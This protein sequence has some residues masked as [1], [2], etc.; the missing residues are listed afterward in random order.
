MTLLDF[1][2]GP[3]MQWSLII[4]IVGILW[5]VVGTLLLSAEKDYSQARQGGTGPGIRA[6]F[7]RFWPHPEFVKP[8]LF[9]MVGGYTLHIGLFVVIFLFAPHIL[10]FAD[11]LGLPVWANLPNNIIML[12]GA[13]T[14]AS[15]VAFVLR[16]MTHPVMRR[17]SGFDDY[18]SNIVTLLPV[19]T[20]MLAFAHTPI[21]RYETLLALHLL[22]VELLF[23]WI[24]L[25]KL[26]HALFFI[27]SRYQ[28]GAAFGRRGVK[29]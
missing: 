19:V 7:R 9:H 26:A 22:S 6:V 3:G 28:L 14:A 16:R 13:L 12:A 4:L 20:G 1:A 23:V 27:P 17:I 29:V 5:R 25:S 18:A 8:T 15:L 24:P 21:A 10:W 2:R 11:L